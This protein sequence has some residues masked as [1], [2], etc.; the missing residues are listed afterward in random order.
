MHVID[1]FLTTSNLWLK[2]LII[3]YLVGLVLLVMGL[4]LAITSHLN[5]K[6]KPYLIKLGDK[7]LMVSFT[8]IM[9][10]TLLLPIVFWQIWF[11]I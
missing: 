2:G 5:Q 4:V 6:I 8:I 1:L 3:I 9:C 11:L 7:L 10:G